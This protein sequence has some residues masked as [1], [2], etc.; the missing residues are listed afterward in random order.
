MAIR[1][2]FVV[3]FF[4]CA[5][6][7]YTQ[8]NGQ[9]KNQRPASNAVE[10]ETS[11]PAAPPVYFYTFEQPAFIVPYVRIEHDRNGAG[12]IYFRKKHLEDEFSR[13]LALSEV[14]IAR[15]TDYWNKLDFLDSTEDYQSNLDYRHLGT[16]KL[17]MALDEKERLAEFNWT[18][19]SHARALTD[20]YKKIGYQY[21]WMFEMEIAMRNQPLETPKLMKRIDSF[22][23]RGE[24]SD[25]M[26]LMPYLKKLGDDERL[27]LIARNHAKR[28][29][30]K[31]EKK[32]DK[33]KETEPR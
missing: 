29:A 9:K 5:S 10:K 20:E 13:P 21:V 1:V 32:A 19:N 6:T 27:P 17:K 2:L 8:N 28:L 31:I 24:I 33:K 14:T 3:L 25:P 18:N 15:L 16:M 11:K 30:D 22:L 26:E 7:A 4:V 23:R 12:M